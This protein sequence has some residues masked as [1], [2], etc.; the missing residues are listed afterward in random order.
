MTSMPAARF[1]KD[2][3]VDRALRHSVR[4]GMAYSIAA[5]GGETYFS[6][7]AL[8]L[9]A[10]APQ[11]AL[12]TTL[13]PLV[14]SFAQLFSAWCGRFVG[15]KPL[16]LIGASLQA[17]L[18]LPILALPQWFGNE[19]VALLLVLFALYHGGG[20]FAAPQWT[21]LM[22][23]L[24]SDRRRGR[25]FGYRTRRTTIAS[26]AAL[27][28]CGLILHFFDAAGETYAGFVVVFLISF[29]ARAVSV[30]HLA[31]L[32]EPATTQAPTIDVHIS[33]W[34]EIVKSSG[35]V[36]FTSY[37]V[38]MNLAVGI[39]SP[40]FAVY[41]L[42][43]LEMTYFEFTALTG[44][45]VF[46]QFLTLNMWGRIADVY[47]NRAIMIV[48]SMA[49]PIVPLLWLASGNFF[50]LL[51]AQAAS[52]LSWAGF[53][54]SAGNL[55]YDLVPRSRRAAYVA[56]HNVGHAGCVFIGAM[57]GAVLAT[58][59]P[60]AEPLLG[61]I[62]RPSNLLYLFAV[63]GLVR[64]VIAAGFVRRIRELRKPRRAI[65]APALVLRVTGFNAMLGLI[66]E[67]IGHVPPAASEPAIDRSNAP[68]AAAEPEPPA[69]S[70]SAAL[71]QSE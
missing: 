61:E 8:F 35:A 30:Y 59:L 6:A 36:G 55:L 3:V 9:K 68:R 10:T 40:F 15:R 47:G 11:V 2:P 17:L 65:S 18:W 67:F 56:F 29:V 5:G 28:V 37:F 49:L 33:H 53:T 25:Y 13:P 41:M 14:G 71:P 23:D 50:Y 32:H 54:L 1:A 62:P 26:F 45:S 46:V 66:Y 7:F 21:S 48:T 58:R 63:S 22:R 70:S 31:Y 20:N 4:D 39:S 27:V 44:M 43:D 42:R 69:A 24:V 64:A 60:A 12:L 38:L 52:G 16:V 19:A 57:L 34:W 51:L